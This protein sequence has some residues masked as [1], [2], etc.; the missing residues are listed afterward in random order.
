[1]WLGCVGGMGGKRKG[2]GS[3]GLFLSKNILSLSKGDCFNVVQ[4]VYKSSLQCMLSLEIG[5]SATWGE[6]IFLDYLYMY[7]LAASMVFH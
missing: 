3:F 7:S 5:W 4:I 1:M 6:C 2:R